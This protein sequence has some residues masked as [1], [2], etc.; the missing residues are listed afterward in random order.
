MAILSRC[1]GNHFFCQVISNE[2]TFKKK[3]K[4]MMLIY[5]IFNI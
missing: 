5:Y 3:I 2:A 1:I 4:I